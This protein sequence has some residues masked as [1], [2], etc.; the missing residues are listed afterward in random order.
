MLVIMVITVIAMSGCAKDGAT[1][2]A[3]QNGTNGTNGTNA[4]VIS[5]ADSAAYN[6]ADGSIGARLYDHL[7]SEANITTP[8]VRN[9]PNF[10]RCKQCHG[11]DLRGSM[12][13]YINR[14]ANA[15][16]PAV[17]PNDIYMYAKLHDIKQIFDAVK[18]TGGTTVGTKSTDSYS[19]AMPDYGKLLSDAQVWD[20]VKFLK[21]D[22]HNFDDF[23]DMNTSGMYPTGTV[24]FKNIGRGGDPVAGLATYNS[25]CKS[26]HGANGT[27][28][29]VYC[30]G[31]YMGGFFRSN[32][33]ELIHKGKWGMPMDI[34]H[35]SCSYAGAMSVFATITDQDLRN[36][37]VMGQDTVAFP[38][39]AKDSP[40]IDE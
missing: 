2:P 18:H 29:N 37:L 35:P 9:Y 24:S 5:A 12:G 34:D 8:A 15:S 40:F 27:Q 25:L 28:I 21:K 22:A 1:G 11:W 4:N 17:A 10:F 19:A 23:Y 32:P 30:Q 6:A 3:G 16:R 31:E 33:H 20:I 39:T 26:C 7:I 36:M 38:S 14:A 13:A